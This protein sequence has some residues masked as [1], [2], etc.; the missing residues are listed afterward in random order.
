MKLRLNFEARF[1]IEFL[2]LVLAFESFKKIV[3]YGD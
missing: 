1:D 2:R 3:S